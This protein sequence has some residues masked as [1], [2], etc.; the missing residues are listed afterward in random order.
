MK[1]TMLILL[2]VTFLAY[3]YEVLQYHQSETSE[4]MR[5]CE[6]IGLHPSAAEIDASG[7]VYVI[8][9]YENDSFGE[10]IE[11]LGTFLAAGRVLSDVEWT[12]QSIEID[13]LN[14]TATMTAA[15]CIAMYEHDNV[16][17][18]AFEQLFQYFT[19]NSTIVYY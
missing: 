16:G 2:A 13:F 14:G 7:N 15:S 10:I 11:C 18:W 4:I 17:D 12:P 1:G 5:L 19:D 9:G 8:F 6:G 3:G